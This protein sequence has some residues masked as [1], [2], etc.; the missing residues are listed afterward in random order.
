VTSGR[1][2]VAHLDD[3]ESVAVA[4]VNWRPVRRRFGITAFGVNA[5]TGDTGEHVVEEHTEARLRHEELYVVLR[6]GAR[7]TLD[8]EELDVESGGLVFV[9][10]P[11]VRRAAVARSDGTTVLGLGARPGEPYTASA[12]E[13]Y[14][15]A[16][17]AYDARDFVA[18]Y[19]IA[20][21]GLPAHPDS[22]PLHYQLACFAARDG[23]DDLA[24]QHLERAFGLD[25]A[26][27]Q[28]AA[29]DADL[30]SLRGAPPL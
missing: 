9:R 1:Y 27:R 16:Q 2:G 5:Y 11:E 12:W 6:G 23:R 30:D 28:W 22:A 26:T 24:R 7:F 10:D 25:D 4:G 18:A 19:D 20:A 13:Y 29:E 14:F 17:P 8:G 3:L 15:A 21:E